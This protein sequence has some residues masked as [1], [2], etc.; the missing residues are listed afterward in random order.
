MTSLLPPHITSANTPPHLFL[1]LGSTPVQARQQAARFMASTQLVVYQST[2]IHDQEI[3][4]ATH[5]HFWT[6]MATAITANRLFCQ[7]LLQELQATGIMTMEELLAVQPGY[8]SKLLHILTHMLD[9]F[10]GTDSSFYNLIED[11]HWLSITLRT[12]IKQ[13]PENY[14]LV[15][16]WHGPVTSSLLHRGQSTEQEDMK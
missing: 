3:R 6:D 7:E 12:T 15:P 10:F 14:W 4:S 11:S 13:N 9:G 2:T 5:T 8:P 16:V 1:T